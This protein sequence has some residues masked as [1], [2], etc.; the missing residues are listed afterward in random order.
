MCAGMAALEGAQTLK[1]LRIL[2]PSKLP[3]QRRDEGEGVSFT[4]SPPSPGVGNPHVTP[5]VSRARC[6]LVSS[7]NSLTPAGDSSKDV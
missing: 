5:E 7:P 4:L 1:K 2:S 3:C 6:T